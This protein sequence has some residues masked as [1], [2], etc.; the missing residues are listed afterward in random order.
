MIAC[1]P[2]VFLFVSAADPFNLDDYLA[3]RPDLPTETIFHIMDQLGRALDDLHSKRGLVHND[4]KPA[5]VG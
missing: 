5:Q 4:L 3:A 2:R 1:T